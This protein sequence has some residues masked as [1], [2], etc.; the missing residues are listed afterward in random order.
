MTTKLTNG[1]DAASQSLY[2]FETSW[3]LDVEDGLDLLRVHINAPMRD[4]EAK[5]FLGWYAKDALE[6]VQHHLI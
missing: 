5:E 1:C 3:P 4:N 6:C 2:I